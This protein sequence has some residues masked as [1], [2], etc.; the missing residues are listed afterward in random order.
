M[1]HGTTHDVLVIGAG[2]AGLSAAH[3]LIGADADVLV[4]SDTVGGR[5]LY[6]KDQGVNYGTYFVMKDYD[7]AKK[8]VSVTDW[9]NPLSCRFFDEDGASY[10]TLSLN[11]L[12][13]SPGFLA[14]LAGMAQFIRHYAKFKKNCEV[15]S[16]REAM[17]LDPYIQKLYDQP[18][19]AWIAEHRIGGFA[20]DYISKFSYACTGVDSEAINAL[21]FCNVTHGLVLQMNL[22]TFDAEEQERAL[23]EHFVK[24]RVVSYEEKNGTHTVKTEQG[25]LFHARNIIFATPAFETAELL[26]LETAALRATSALYVENIRG[27]IRP[28]F[29]AQDMNLFPFTSPVIFTARQPGGT[30]LVYSREPEI[31]KEELFSKWELLGRKDWKKAE[32]VVGN[33]YLEQQYGPSTFVAGDHNGLGLEP[34]AISG[35]YAA[36]QVLKS[37]PTA[38]NAAA[39]TFV[40]TRESFNA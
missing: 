23:G 24:D 37:L 29:D 1:E 3:R 22:F 18:A 31:D 39:P 21:D 30:Y 5:T 10:P 17:A 13:R 12:K 20:K 38:P 26:G 4:V 2:I 6:D 7:H 14:F 32:Y 8:F 16:Q 9:I 19:S 15:V 36:N 25:N 35:I 11:T 33:A 40:P 27:T 28:G 34:A